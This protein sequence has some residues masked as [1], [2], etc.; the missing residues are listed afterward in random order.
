MH[1]FPQHRA[2]NPHHRGLHDP[3]RR[4]QAILDLDREDLVS[5]PVDHVLLAVEDAHETR[6][7]DAAQVAGV[8]PASG[9]L[10]RVGLRIR[11]V[12]AHHHRA[13]DPEL[14]GVAG[15]DLAAVVVHHHDA[16]CGHHHADTVRV[17]ASEFR[18]HHGGGRSGL[19][20]AVGIHQAQRRQSLREF[21]DRGY[22][23]RRA[24]VAAD[25]PGRQVVA[26]EIGLHQAEL[27]HRRHQDRVVDPLARG[28]LEERAGGEGRHHHGRTA[29]THGSQHDRHQSGHV[30][31][32]HREHRA[33]G[34][35]E[36]RAVLE[37]HHRMH[38]AQMRE[39]R[40]LG[41]AGGAGGVEQGAAVF[42][43]WCHEAWGGRRHDSEF[44]ECPGVRC[45]RHA[46]GRTG[47]P[48]QL[49]RLRARRHRGRECVVEHDRARAAL[50]DDEAHA[51]ALFARAD[52]YR[53]RAEALARQVGEVELGAI[54]Q[55]QRDPITPRDAE[56]GQAGGDRF[57]P[58]RA[59]LVG[60]ASAVDD[61]RFG[62]RV[63]LQ[64]ALEQRP[65]MSGAL[66]EATD[67]AV[68]EMSLG[69]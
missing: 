12:A 44:V 45:G 13:R 9:E 69:P 36:A 14:A 64:C 52:R 47:D 34:G 57:D 22:R 65:H 38:D 50:A 66:C 35:A 4:H 29:A 15:R 3:R 23:H 6:A 53:D 46:V 8:P 26:I 1:A 32:R 42:L 33:G 39:H 25:R 54:R 43:V 67:Q 56:F 28:E 21:V 41:A 68:A 37:V 60:P 24:A 59:C 55:Q 49:R 30:A 7:V 17:F 16:P 19:G 31:R 51:V 40:A 2:R 63:P 10:L 18:R 27:V 48:H 62:L 61:Q 11:P 58:S 5:A 20:G